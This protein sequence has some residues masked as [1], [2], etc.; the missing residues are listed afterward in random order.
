MSQSLGSAGTKIPQTRWLEQPRLFLTDLE[1]E[2]PRL[3]HG[4]IWCL[5][6]VHCREAHFI[7]DHLCHVSLYG[8]G[9]RKLSM[10]SF[11]RALVPFTRD[12]PPNDP[13]SSHQHIGALGVRVSTCEFGE[14]PTCSIVPGFFK[15][16]PCRILR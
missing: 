1:A 14:T 8:A 4:Q 15:V 11:I 10:I 13:I 5:L 6:R 16:R 9:M 12:T 7:N 3:R 2:S